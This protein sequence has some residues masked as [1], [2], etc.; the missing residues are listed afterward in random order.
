M[1]AAAKASGTDSVPVR[2]LQLGWYDDVTEGLARCKVCGKT[3]AFDVV[4]TSPEGGRIY[5][6]ARIAEAQFLAVSSA[7]D[8]APP[9]PD[10]VQKWREAIAVATVRTATDQSDRDLLVLADDLE[11]EILLA[12]RID[13]RTWREFLDIFVRKDSLAARMRCSRLPTGI[14]RADAPGL[15]AR[16]GGRR[17]C[18]LDPQRIGQVGKRAPPSTAADG[19]SPGLPDAYRSGRG[20]PGSLPD[21]CRSG[22]GEPVSPAE[23]PMVQ[24]AAH[25]A[26]SHAAPP[27]SWAVHVLRDC[28]LTYPEGLPDGYLPG[29]SDALWTWDNN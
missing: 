26:I 20:E 4:A 27:H 24:Y 13:F 28:G 16:G 5:G 19:A 22:R 6:F 10:Q 17:G 3:Y 21:A 25:R 9:L 8:R 1:L 29:T 15:A 2:D 18:R 14:V 7:L 12:Q 11:E 23:T